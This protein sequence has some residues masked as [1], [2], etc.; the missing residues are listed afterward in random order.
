MERG[1]L[2]GLSDDDTRAVLSSMVRRRYQRHET[3]FHEGDPGDTLHLVDRGRVA[4][5][6]T[7]RLGDVVTVAVLGRGETFGE[8]A[9]LS[10]NSLRT[11]SVVALEPVVTR[12]LRRAD[13]ARMRAEHPS[14]DRMMVQLLSRD[15]HRLT[16]R[17]LEALYDDVEQ[18]VVRRIAELVELYAEDDITE[19]SIPLR[20]ADLASMAGTTRPTTN[21][22]LRSLEQE[23]IVE[24]ARGRLVV[25]DR[26]R[27]A[28]SARRSP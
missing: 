17:L 22:V 9:L 8:Q 13:F 26:P 3:L 12:S 24:L 7:T 10:A 4:V 19:V 14:V 27:L 18:R 15:V 23:G 21:R 11:A 1:V 5:R 6:V 2:S 20:Q 25:L 16:D 28:H